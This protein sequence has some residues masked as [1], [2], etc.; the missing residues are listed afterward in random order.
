MIVRVWQR[1]FNMNVLFPYC[2]PSFSCRLEK[3][4][5]ATNPAQVE[6]RTVLHS[7]REEGG[8]ADVVIA[9]SP[10][11]DYLFHQWPGSFDSH[12]ISR[13]TNRRSLRSHMFLLAIEWNSVVHLNKQ[14]IGA[15]EFF[16]GKPS[17]LFKTIIIGLLD[18]L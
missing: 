9:I 10:R 18:H 3:H 15:I 5:P 8:S 17:H 16:R 14:K 2:T 7:D 11:A 13:P 4:P 1:A 12:S 6:T